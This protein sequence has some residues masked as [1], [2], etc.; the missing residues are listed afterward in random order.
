MSAHHHPRLANN[1]GLHLHWA[2]TALPKRVGA[3][4]LHWAKMRKRAAEQ[5]AAA[6]A[7]SGMVAAKLMGGEDE[8][9]QGVGPLHPCGGGGGDGP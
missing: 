2:L 9:E 8:N 5:S 4:D 7:A 6:A 3:G 1:P